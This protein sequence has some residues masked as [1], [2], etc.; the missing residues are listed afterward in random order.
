MNWKVNAIILSFALL[1][2]LLLSRLVSCGEAPQIKPDIQTPGDTFYESCFSST[3]STGN[4]GK[5]ESLDVASQYTDTQISLEEYR[6]YESKGQKICK[7]T[8]EFLYDEKFKTV[9]PNFLANPKTGRCMEIDCYN[10]RLKIGLEY[11]GIQH[12]VWPNFTGQSETDF[13]K[14]R[15]RDRLKNII[16]AKNGV[17]LIRVSYKVPFAAIP[18]YIKM[19][20]PKA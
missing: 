18:D 10:E 6:G 19:K 7:E 16:C 14:Q 1:S 5:S 3:R 20:A 17:H 13:L 8:L 12:Y 11:D 15:Q 9:R 2:V 4:S